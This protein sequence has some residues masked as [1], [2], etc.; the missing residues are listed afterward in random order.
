MRDTLILSLGCEY[1]CFGESFDYFFRAGYRLDPQPLTEP[2]TTLHSFSGGLGILW[3]KLQGDIGFAYFTGS[4]EDVRQNHFVFC[5][6]LSYYF[7]GE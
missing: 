1:A 6:S 3:K 4:A 2:R 7:K 5:T